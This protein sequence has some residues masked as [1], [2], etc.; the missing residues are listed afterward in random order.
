FST[1]RAVAWYTGNESIKWIINN[2]NE[3]YRAA[4]NDV[5]VN[6]RKND[7]TIFYG[8]FARTPFEIYGVN[9]I[10]EIASGSY[11]AGGGSDLPDP[12][13]PLIN[14]FHYPHVWFVLLHSEG[15]GAPKANA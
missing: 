13:L 1:I 15:N 2:E 11:A 9:K 4:A 6:K 14:S 5:L 12:N 7:I 3:D 10:V 8:Y